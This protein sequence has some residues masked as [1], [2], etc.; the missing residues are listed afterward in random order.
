MSGARDVFGAYVDP[1]VADMSEMVD[2]LPRPA[3]EVEYTRAWLGSN[4]V[5]NKHASPVRAAN[6][7]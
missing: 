6:N 7:S 3:S 4:I 5:A 1:D 2:E